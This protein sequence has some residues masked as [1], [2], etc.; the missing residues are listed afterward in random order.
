MFKADAMN[1][2]SAAYKALEKAFA[3]NNLADSR[4]WAG[5][6]NNH[7]PQFIHFE[8][9]EVVPY[10]NY[11]NVANA[12]KNTKYINWKEPSVLMT[13][14]KAVQALEIFIDLPD[15]IDDLQKVA[16]ETT[17]YDGAHVAGGELFFVGNIF[18]Y[19]DYKS[20]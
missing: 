9:D 18:Y 11:I 16:G 7:K 6:T 4:N 12:L 19:K 2:S 3:A 10:V 20:W 14:I 1:P 8:C 17:P 13:I 5:G 15:I